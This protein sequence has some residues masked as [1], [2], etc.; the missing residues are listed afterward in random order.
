MRLTYL[1]QSA[2]P[3]SFFEMGTVIEKRMD[4]QNSYISVDFGSFIKKRTIKKENLYNTQTSLTRKN[5]FL[6]PFNLVCLKL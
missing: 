6:K 1:V 3:K 5:L 2:E 4:Y